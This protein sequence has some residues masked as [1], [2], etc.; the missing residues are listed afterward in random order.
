MALAA[1]ISAYHETGE[2]GSPL[3]ATLPLAG[4]TVVER[5]ARLAAA[6]GAHPVVVFVERVTAELAAALD[7]LR[8]EGVSPIL[9]RSVAEAAEAIEPDDRLLLIGD[10]LVAEPAHF[11]RVAALPASPC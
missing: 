1:L 7:R 9:A 10:G 2:P 5:Q 11:T 4:R 6:V 3:R 8:G